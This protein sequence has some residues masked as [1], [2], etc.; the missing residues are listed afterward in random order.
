[1]INK[2]ILFLLPI[3]TISFFVQ[4]DSRYFPEVIGIQPPL[5]AKVLSPPK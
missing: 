2:K 4:A 3:L 1:M 5:R